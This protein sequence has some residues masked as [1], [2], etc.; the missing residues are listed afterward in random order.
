MAKFIQLFY[1]TPPLGMPHVNPTIETWGAGDTTTPYVISPATIQSSGY[2]G[3]DNEIG[4]PNY[5]IPY[6][7][8]SGPDDGHKWL[9][10]H[11]FY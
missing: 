6:D 3:V 10:D 8:V 11:P 7:G 9:Q 4:S 2:S 1:G 5:F